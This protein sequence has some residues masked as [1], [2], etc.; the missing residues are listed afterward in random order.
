MSRGG[1]CSLFVPPNQNDGMFVDVTLFFHWFFHDAI[2]TLSESVTNRL[3]G[4]NHQLLP[5]GKRKPRKPSVM[6]CLP[7]TFCFTVL[8]S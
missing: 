8:D 3:L 4:R 7:T 5:W 6:S 1:V 2:L